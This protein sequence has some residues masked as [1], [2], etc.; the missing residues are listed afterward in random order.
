[1]E[2]CQGL[3][4]GSFCRQAVPADN[5]AGKEKK[6]KKREQGT[7]VDLDGPVLGVFLAG[8]IC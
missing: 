6:K 5:C 4:H 3:G 2:G 1:M 7:E 8:L